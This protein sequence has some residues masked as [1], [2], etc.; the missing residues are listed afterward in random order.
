MSDQL[1][2]TCVAESAASQ[3]LPNGRDSKQSV[4]P[5]LQN[6]PAEL[7]PKSTPTSPTGGTYETRPLFDATSLPAAIHA[8]RFPLQDEDAERKIIATSGHQC[9]LRLDDTTTIGAFSKM[10]LESKDWFSPDALMTWRQEAISAKHSIFRL[11][12]LDY[13]A[14]NG[15]F[16]LLPRVTASDWKGVRKRSFRGSESKERFSASG[17]R[18]M[19]SLRTGPQDGIYPPPELCEA[20]KGFPISASALKASET[21]SRR[22]LRSKS[23]KQSERCSEK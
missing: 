4:L 17:G 22:L 23:S 1:T 20:V 5:K 11:A 9:S 8:S 21:P 14:W 3:S 7:L 18:F 15:T 10:L 16:G 6:T 12:V 19:Q 13:Q 2:L